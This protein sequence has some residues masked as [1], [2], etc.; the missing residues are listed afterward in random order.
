MPGDRTTVAG[1]RLGALIRHARLKEG[2]TQENLADLL[3]YETSRVSKMEVGKSPPNLGKIT[4]IAHAIGQHRR[5]LAER[6]DERQQ[7]REEGAVYTTPNE[8]DDDLPVILTL[9]ERLPAAK[10][11]QNLRRFRRE[12]EACVKP[13]GTTEQGK[14]GPR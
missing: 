3:G 1:K 10:R 4:R 5:E 11:H 14:G 2:L 8:H 9:L 7:V 6:D 12:L 13:T